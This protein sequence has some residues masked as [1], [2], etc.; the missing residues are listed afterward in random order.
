VRKAWA[1]RIITAAQ[2]NFR[3]RKLLVIRPSRRQNGFLFQR[4]RRPRTSQFIF[5][6]EP[7]TY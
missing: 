3:Y 1:W 5:A 4:E 2:I 7:L 6:S